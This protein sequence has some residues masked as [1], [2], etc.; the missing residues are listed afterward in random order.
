MVKSL[1]E[2]LKER[3]RDDTQMTRLPSWIKV[4]DQMVQNEWRPAPYELAPPSINE[5]IYD[6][7]RSHPGDRPTAAEV[8]A[9][10]SGND[11]RGG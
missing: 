6:C 1:L 4:V 10:L 8:L 3:F 11:A 9:R 5:L 7:M 2:F